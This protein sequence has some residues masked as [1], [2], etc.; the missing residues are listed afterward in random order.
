MLKYYNYL[1]IPFVTARN[2]DFSES[3]LTMAA[4]KILEFESFVS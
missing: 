3:G 4:A 2:S 1:I